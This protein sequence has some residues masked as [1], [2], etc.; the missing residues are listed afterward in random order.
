M[1]ALRLLEDHPFEF[2]IFEA[3]ELNA[4]QSLSRAKSLCVMFPFP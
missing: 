1:E 2:G 3:Q 4:K